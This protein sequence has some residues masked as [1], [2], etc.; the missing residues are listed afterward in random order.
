MCCMHDKAEGA[1]R[2]QVIAAFRLSTIA[3]C[4]I[5][6]ISVFTHGL[7]L[8]LLKTSTVAVQA[9]ALRTR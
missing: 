2:L 9:L 4:I 7:H 3:H 6:G 5:H 8:S 1:V